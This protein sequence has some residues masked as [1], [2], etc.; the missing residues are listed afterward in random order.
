MPKR[1]VRKSAVKNH[2]QSER[3]RL[4]NKARNSELATIEKKIRAAAA[5][6]DKDAATKLLVEFQSELDTTAKA[7]G[8]KGNKVSRKKS[9]LSALVAAIGKEAPK[10]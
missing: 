3:A 1:I 7:G 8:I 10:A 2:R 9:R 5:A 4:R 6:K